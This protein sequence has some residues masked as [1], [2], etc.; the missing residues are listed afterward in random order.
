MAH[1]VLKCLQNQ[2]KPNDL[3]KYLDQA[4]NISVLRL[5]SLQR[6][7]EAAETVYKSFLTEFMSA[8]IE[9]KFKE[10]ESRFSCVVR[11]A[12]Y[13]TQNLI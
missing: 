4:R 7:L 5:K 8:I 3:Q 1:S 11:G 10:K 9:L 13:E 6:I 12:D 2:S